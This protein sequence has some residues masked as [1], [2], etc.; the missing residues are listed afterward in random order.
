MHA[1]IHSIDREITDPAAAQ[2]DRA[3]AQ[4]QT[5]LTEIVKMLQTFRNLRALQ[6]PACHAEFDE[7]VAKILMITVVHQFSDI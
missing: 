5:S 2:Q 3:H 7:K 4:L 1:F 6:E